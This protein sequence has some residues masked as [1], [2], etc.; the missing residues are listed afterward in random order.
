MVLEFWKGTWICL[1]QIEP[2]ATQRR[3]FTSEPPALSI[4]MAMIKLKIPTVTSQATIAQGAT[5]I[6][7]RVPHQGVHSKPRWTRRHAKRAV[8]PRFAWNERQ[9]GLAARLWISTKRDVL[10]AKGR[11]FTR[12]PKATGSRQPLETL[13]GLC[14]A[15]K[16]SVDAPILKVYCEC[17]IAL[18]SSAQWPR[19]RPLLP[20]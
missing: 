12:A 10:F 18:S 4:K 6:A 7:L 16:A 3:H 5:S 2:K 15:L 9:V 13:L 11:S 8:N 14:L 20:G 17:I 19:N 1:R